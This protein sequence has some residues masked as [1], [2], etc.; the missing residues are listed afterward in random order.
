MKF[1]FVSIATLQDVPKDGI[2]GEYHMMFVYETQLTMC[3]DII[4]VVKEVGEMSSITSKA[5]NKVVSRFRYGG[6]L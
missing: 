3:K 4:G 5:T 2:C 1:N 6:I